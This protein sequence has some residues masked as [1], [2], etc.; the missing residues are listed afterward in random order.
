MLDEPLSEET[1]RRKA[2]PHR[3]IIGV[4]PLGHSY[5]GS[6]DRTSGGAIEEL[7]T[8]GPECPQENFPACLSAKGQAYC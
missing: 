1:Q 5:A 6:M 8:A 7:I 4:L 3:E 2:R